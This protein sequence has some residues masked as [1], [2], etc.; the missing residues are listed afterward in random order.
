MEDKE[1]LNF[2]I[3][4]NLQWHQ[5]A[6]TSVIILIIVLCQ[7]QVRERTLSLRNETD[8][9]EITDFCDLNFE[10][11]IFEFAMSVES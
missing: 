8:K 4:V 7:V 1:K 9:R 3:I 6:V 11:T 5:F 2:T 10:L